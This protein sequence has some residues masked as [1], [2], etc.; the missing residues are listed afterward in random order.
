MKKLSNRILGTIIA[1]IFLA[2][3]TITFAVMTTAESTIFKSIIYDSGKISITLDGS[4]SITGHGFYLGTSENDMTKYS[5]PESG[6]VSSI[7]FILS[8]FTTLSP[9]TTYYYQIWVTA[10][11]TTYLSDK[12][13]FAIP[14]AQP[15]MWFMDDMYFTQLPGGGY[16]HLGTC[17]F[18]VIGDNGKRDILLHSIAK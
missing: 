16:S 11:G 6:T 13:S 18:D 4:Y 8:E 9:E 17:N 7:Y 3:L 5:D 15:A 12:R 10:N 2:S 1:L 14:K